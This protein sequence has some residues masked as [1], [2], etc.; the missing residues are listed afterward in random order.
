MDKPHIIQEIRKRNVS[1][2]FNNKTIELDSKTVTRLKK[3]ISCCLMLFLFLNIFPRVNFIK[4][5]FFYLPLAITLFLIYLKK[6]DFSIKSPLLLPIIMFTVWA[7][8][9]SIFAHNVFESFHSFYSHLVRYI[10]F[11]CLFINFLDTKSKII[12]LSWVI[13]LSTIIFFA[14]ALIY[15]YITLQN[16]LSSR[17][18]FSYFSINIISFGTIFSILLS[19]QLLSTEQFFFR[20]S[21]LITG[22]ILL[23]AA[24]LLTQSRGAFISLVISTL[25]ILARNKFFLI[26]FIVILVALTSILPGKNRISPDKIFDDN[27]RIGILYYSLEIVKDYPVMGTGFSIDVFK[28]KKIMNQEKYWENIPEQYRS[29]NF[30]LPHSMPLSL[31]VRTGIIGLILFS[32]IFITLFRMCFKI[33]QSGKNEFLKGWGWCLVAT[34]VMFIISGLF[35]PVFIHSLDTIFYTICAMITIIWKINEKA[36]SS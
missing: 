31:L 20:K 18:G 11:Y 21:I 23:V 24:T 32:F 12:T 15:Y 8:L 19:F 1:D 28:N 4:D 10:I 34:L 22:I 3:I 26:S 17:F 9:I 13:V 14:G 33:I 29:V 27:A 2:I 7:F 16:P 6:L 36:D 25:I 30:I 5:I 35:E